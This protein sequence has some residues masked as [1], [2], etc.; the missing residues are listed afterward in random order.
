MWR[1]AY[2]RRVQPIIRVDDGE[3]CGWVRETAAACE[4]LTVF[5]GRLEFCASRTDAEL[6][7]RERGLA[8]LMERW[9]L[10]DSST[11]ERQVALLQEATPDAVTVV[12]GYYSLPGV[13]TLRIDR[14][15]L[16]AGRYTLEL[17][18]ATP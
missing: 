12:L 17:G 7:V 13:P 18:T 14:A 4:A 15:D 5:G 1:S 3:L 8:S 2:R 10:T 11:G 6:V 9:T 16:E